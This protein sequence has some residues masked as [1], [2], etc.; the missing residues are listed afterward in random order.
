M[1]QERGS[2]GANFWTFLRNGRTVATNLDVSIK[3]TGTI[4]VNALNFLLDF[5]NSFC[6]D[7]VPNIIL[8]S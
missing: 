2:G 4:I 8:M 3:C 5:F 6:I 1:G 7:Y